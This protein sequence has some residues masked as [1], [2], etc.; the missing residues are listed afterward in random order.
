[1][2]H[3]ALADGHRER[4]D[5]RTLVLKA[6]IALVDA[7]KGLLLSR[8]DADD[9]GDLDLVVAEGF[10]HD[11]ADS[12][13]VPHFAREVLDRDEIVRRDHPVL[14]ADANHTAADDEIDSIV[15]T[16]LF[17]RDRFAG[18]VICAN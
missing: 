5:A 17:L 16:P 18:V 12:G 4:D 8:D 9:D 15:A 3:A 7:E 13:L 2:E 1:D 10:E 6:A 11:P 14:P